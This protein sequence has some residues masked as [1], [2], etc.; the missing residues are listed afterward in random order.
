LHYF[1]ENKTTQLLKEEM[2]AAT[3]NDLELGV[4]W[5]YGRNDPRI[6][7]EEQKYLSVFRDAR[8]KMAHLEPL[9]NGEIKEIFSILENLEDQWVSFFDR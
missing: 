3:P 6:S 2:Q 7:Q 4:L 1:E 9:D 5:Y 8:N